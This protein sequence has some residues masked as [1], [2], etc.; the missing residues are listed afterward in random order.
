MCRKLPAIVVHPFFLLWGAESHPQ[1]IRGHGVDTRYNVPLFFFRKRA[2]WRTIGARH[3]D[4]I[5]SPKRVR[6]AFCGSGDASIKEMTVSSF[7]FTAECFHQL[8]PIDST[9]EWMP[10]PPAQPDE[11][12]PVGNHQIGGIE[13]EPKLGVGARL[14]DSVHTRNGYIP[15]LCAAFDP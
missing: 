8:W 13:C 15:P 6:E 12:H 1:N 11:R 5:T 3:Y 14:G 9:F 4:P 10:M 7:G 2:E